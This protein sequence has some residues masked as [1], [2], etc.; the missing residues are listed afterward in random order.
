MSIILNETMKKILYN[1]LFYR[2]IFNFKKC[3]LDLGPSV[4]TGSCSEGFASCGS[5]DPAN[6]FWVYHTG[7]VNSVA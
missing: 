1:L 2:D 5:A 3:Y 7:S 6:A 4:H